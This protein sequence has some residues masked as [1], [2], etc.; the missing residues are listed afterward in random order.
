MRRKAAIIALAVSA[1]LPDVPALA[2]TGS[3]EKEIALGRSLAQEMERHEKLLP[4]AAVAEYGIEYATQQ[5]EALL[6][7]GVQGLHFYTLN[8]AHS[9]VRIV[10]NLGLGQ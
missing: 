4:D 3:V 7:F 9:T 8:K 2:Q 5:C 10:K 6:R 1:I